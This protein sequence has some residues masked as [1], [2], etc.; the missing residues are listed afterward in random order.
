MEKTRIDELRA[1]LNAIGD[2]Q[3]D[4][5]Q[6]FTNFAIKLEGSLGT[7]LG[8]PS[9]VALCTNTGHFDF[10]RGSYVH[11]GLGFD[12][13]EYRIPLMLRICHTKDDGAFLL[14]FRIFC[15][16]EG[17]KLIARFGNSTEVLTMRKDDDLEKLNHFIFENVRLLLSPESWFKIPS[18]DYQDTLIGFC[19]NS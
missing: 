3:I 13:G 7:F 15:T 2:M 8:S 14:R 18:L 16:L 4:Y 19:K 1:S 12:D 5:M 11:Q 17:E 6:F 9:D 10:E